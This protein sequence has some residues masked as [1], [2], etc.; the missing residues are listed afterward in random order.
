MEFN[1]WSSQVQ[2][3]KKGRNIKC[4]FLLL[5][6]TSS[7]NLSEPWQQL[8]FKP[9]ISSAQEPSNPDSRKKL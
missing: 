5:T 9:K 2:I 7:V 8:H 1:W 6:F 4:S 3:G